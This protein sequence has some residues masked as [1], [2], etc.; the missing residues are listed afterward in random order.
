MSAFVLQG[1]W[2]NKA[3]NLGCFGLGFSLSLFKGF[4]TTLEDAMLFTEMERLSDTAGFGVPV[5]GAH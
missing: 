5:A 3:L 2:S 4:L 1:V